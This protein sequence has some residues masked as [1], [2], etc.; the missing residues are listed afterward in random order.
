[1]SHQATA[2]GRFEIEELAGGEWKCL[3]SAPG[4]CSESFRLTIPHRGELRNSR[5]DLLPVRERIFELYRD[6]AAPLLPDEEMWGIWTPRQI[7]DHVRGQR[8]A[9]ALESLTDYVEESYFSQR[10]PQ[11]SDLDGAARMVAATMDESIKR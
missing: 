6:A 5:I 11:E 1:V 7:F 8:P 3:A 10:T 4:F 2:E 9:A